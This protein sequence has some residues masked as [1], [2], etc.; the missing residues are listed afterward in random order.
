MYQNYPNPFNPDTWVPYQ[1][2]EDADVVIDIYSIKG[3]LVRA[4][5]LG[6]K[7]AG[8]YITKERAAHWDG[9]NAAGEKVASGVYFYQLKAGSYKS[10]VTRMVI[11]K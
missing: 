6:H 5:H 1:I 7:P 4:L 9:K 2:A 3:Q 8:F 10:P 11:L